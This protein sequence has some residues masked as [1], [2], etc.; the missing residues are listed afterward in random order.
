MKDVTSNVSNLKTL[1]DV[2]EYLK[3]LHS[4]ILSGKLSSQ[5]IDFIPI[6]QSIQDIVTT[7]NLRS[8][9]VNFKHSSDLFQRKVSDIRAYIS[10]LGGSKFEQIVKVQTQD[11]LNLVFQ[12][13]YQPPF[14]VEDINMEIILGDFT[15]LVNRAKI[16]DEIEFPDLRNV[17]KETNIQIFDQ[18]IENIHFERDIQKF[19]KQLVPQLPQKLTDILDSA[20]EEVAQ[21]RYSYFVYCLYL[22]QRKKVFFDKK[23][24]ELHLYQADHDKHTKKKLKNANTEKNKRM[25]KKEKKK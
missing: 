15:R 24:N 8:I 22:I 2:E 23:S 11:S 25:K 12:S 6:F 21:A 20:P 17:N 10:S 16:F 3:K 9:V 4:E 7:E 18:Y 1:P 5:D 14:I 19:E 13:M